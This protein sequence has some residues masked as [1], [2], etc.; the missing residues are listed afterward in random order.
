MASV[1]NRRGF[2]GKLF[3]G[4]AAIAAGKASGEA[5]APPSN[6]AIPN[7]AMTINEAAMDTELGPVRTEWVRFQSNSAA[8][9]VD[10][11]QLLVYCRIKGKS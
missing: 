1:N 3:G 8:V 11:I 5:K 9:N 7:G 6:I 4:A 2:F 10:D